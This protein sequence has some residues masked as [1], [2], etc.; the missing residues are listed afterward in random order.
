MTRL[1]TPYLYHVPSNRPIATEIRRVRIERAKRELA[2]SKKTLTE[3]A[4][5]VGFGE[6]MR[7]YEVFRRKMGVSPGKYR[8]Q[9]RLQN[10]T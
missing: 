3:I 1:Q 2:Q 10:G 7:M 4:R 8:K 6:I 9:I 5:D